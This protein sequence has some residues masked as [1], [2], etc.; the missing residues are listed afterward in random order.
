MRPKTSP[1]A[2]RTIYLSKKEWETLVWSSD[3]S[4]F[5]PTHKLVTPEPHCLD[6]FTVGDVRLLIRQCTWNIVV[7]EATGF[8]IEPVST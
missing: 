1:K 4:H 7:I 3:T 6:A 5:C 2:L 8:M